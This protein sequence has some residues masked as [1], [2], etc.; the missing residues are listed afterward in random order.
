MVS[1]AFDYARAASWDDAVA[2]LTAGGEDARAIAGGQSLVP[3]MMLRL[4]A[5][6]VL[7]DLGPIVSP[8][9]RCEDD[10]LEVPALTRHAELEESAVIRDACPMLAEAAA[11][12]GN[13]RVR[14]RGTIG[15]SLAHGEPSA[16]LACV[17]LAHGA[18]V[19]A[20]G[21]AGERTIP[22]ADLVVGALVTSLAPGELITSVRIPRLRDDQGSAFVELARRAGDFAMVE[23][24]AI[25]TLG[26]G[27]VIS[28]ARV[29]LGATGDRPVDHSAL[30]GPLTGRAPADAVFAEVA[31]AVAAAAAIGPSSHAG[32]AYRRRMVAVL[33]RR[34][35]RA[36]AARA[37]ER[38]R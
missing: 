36:A 1:A 19:R 5:P 6:S 29:V 21:P 23:V 14:R 12:I 17:A 34:A 7:V 11:H 37:G 31:D 38:A 33:V 24:A 4:A 32:A 15:G 20:V 25:V 2:Q 18:T 16:E 13:V 3:M 27:G 30:A 8:P 22:A 10:A 35:L 26:D 9:V 28:D